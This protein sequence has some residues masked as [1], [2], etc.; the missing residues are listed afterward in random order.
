[1]LLM[2]A[3]YV[4]TGVKLPTL[5][6]LG[7]KETKTYDES[8]QTLDIKDELIKFDTL[9]KNTSLWGDEQEKGLVPQRVMEEL[10]EL[11]ELEKLSNL[12]DSN[13][14]RLKKLSSSE[15]LKNIKDSLNKKQLISQKD[16]E[17]KLSGEEVNNIWKKLLALEES[18]D[19]HNSIRH[20]LTQLFMLRLVSS[21]REA[22]RDT[23]Q[24]SEIEENK[25]ITTIKATVASIILALEKFQTLSDKTLHH[26]IDRNFVL[27]KY[28]MFR[29]DNKPSREILLKLAKELVHINYY[30]F[31]LANSLWKLK[32]LQESLFRKREIDSTSLELLD[33]PRVSTEHLYSGEG[34]LNYWKVTANITLELGEQ[35]NEIIHHINMYIDSLW[36]DFELPKHYRIEDNLK[37][38]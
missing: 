6:L 31:S 33:V 22:E 29:G 12:D 34:N 7:K 11:E 23:D 2:L 13:K 15:S 37:K 27:R 25:V 36:D 19:T 26:H 8:L 28:K 3:I 10:E 18:Y 35:S 16:Y 14:E 1:M 17:D 4:N 32:D 9:I 5:E 38:S 30:Y 21:V 24:K 20:P